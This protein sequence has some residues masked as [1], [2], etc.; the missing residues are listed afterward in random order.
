MIELNKI[1]ISWGIEDLSEVRGDTTV[2]ESPIH[3]PTNA[4][5]VWDSIKSAIRLLTKIDKRLSGGAKKK[6]YAGIQSKAK[7]LYYQI[8]IFKISMPTLSS[9]KSACTTDGFIRSNRLHTS[10]KF[11][12]HC[13]KKG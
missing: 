11:I 12:V 13:F 1:A 2:V 10:F 5:L 7:K 6:D 4:S 9:C 3:Y 8:N